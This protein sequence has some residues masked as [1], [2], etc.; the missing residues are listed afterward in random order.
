MNTFEIID[1]ASPKWDNII[2]SACFYDFYHTSFYHRIETQYPAVLLYASNGEDFVALPLIIRPIENTDWFDCTS[3][4]GYCGPVSNR[5][6]INVPEDLLVYFRKCCD[7]YFKTQHIISIFSRLHPI[8]NQE[9]LFH[10]FGEVLALNKTVTIQLTLSPEDQKRQYRKSIRSEINQCRNKGFYVKEASSETEIKTFIDIYYGTMER[11]G[12]ARQY[13]FTEE[14][15]H[16]FLNNAAFGKKLLLA[17][18]G[19]QIV[20]G[21]IFTYTDTIMQYHLAGTLPDYMRAAPMKL[22][23]DEAR[24]I[25]NAMGLK[26]LHLGGGVGGSDNDSLFAFKSGF[27]DHYSQF[28]VWRYITDHKKYKSLVHI[29]GVRQKSNIFFPLYR[30]LPFVLLTSMY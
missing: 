16:S 22:I 6:D 20:A 2:Q 24:V 17:K 27:S 19:D 25:G 8:I 30:M 13:F 9:R 4:Y 12:A 3:V 26:F 28:S 21:A 18:L 7:N 29:R 23:I 1:S 15:F 5:A 10:H 11:I 14:Y